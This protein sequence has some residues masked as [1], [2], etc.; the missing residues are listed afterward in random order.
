MNNS[1]THS[2][3]Y[4]LQYFILCQCCFDYCIL[5]DIFFSI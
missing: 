3:T 4:L 1:C 5:W 2:L